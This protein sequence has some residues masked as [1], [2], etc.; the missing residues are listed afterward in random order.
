MAGRTY[1]PEVRGWETVV[2]HLGVAPSVSLA[3]APSLES[4]PPSSLLPLLGHRARQCPDDDCR[5]STRGLGK[6]GRRQQRRARLNARFTPATALSTTRQQASKK[7]LP[8][9]GSFYPVC[10]VAP[11]NYRRFKTA[12]MI[13]IGLM[14]PDKFSPQ[15]SA[16]GL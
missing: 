8:W 1:I 13:Q 7:P 3:L 2:Q 6:S 15:G 4:A 12:R 10:Q 5:P 11:M 16:P 14:M 9:R